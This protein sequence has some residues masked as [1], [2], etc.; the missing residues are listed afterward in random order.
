MLMIE[1]LADDLARV[2][3]L[4]SYLAVPLDPVGEEWISAEALVSDPACLREHS[5]YDRRRAHRS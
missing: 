5:P 4:V 2:T 1:L 3:T